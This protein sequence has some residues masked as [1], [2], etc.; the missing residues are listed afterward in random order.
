[1]H[2]AID[3]FLGEIPMSMHLFRLADTFARTAMVCADVADDVS[4]VVRDET[5]VSHLPH[6]MALYHYFGAKPPIFAH[7]PFV[8]QGANQKMSKSTGN[9]V[10][11]RQLRD[12]GK[13][14]IDAIEWIKAFYTERTSASFTSQAVAIVSCYVRNRG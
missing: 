9:T 6:Y 10:T 2:V 13:S 4:L 1:V 8:T 5:F 12:E 3:A 14:A 11:V 7:I